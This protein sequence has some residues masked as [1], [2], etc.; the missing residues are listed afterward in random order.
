MTPRKECPK[1]RGPAKGSGGRPDLGK[2]KL[3]CRVLPETRAIMGDKPGEW[4]D[5]ELRGKRGKAKK[6]KI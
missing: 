6:P 5:R 3:T 1:K 2:V 4:L